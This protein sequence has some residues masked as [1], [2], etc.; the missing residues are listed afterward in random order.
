MLDNNNGLWKFRARTNRSLPVN[1]PKSFDP[2]LSKNGVVRPIESKTK[3]AQALGLIDR[4]VREKAASPT[5]A[6]AGGS[7][8]PSA[9]GSSAPLAGDSNDAGGDAATRRAQ[10][11]LRPSTF[12]GPGR[13]GD[14][15]W[16]VK[17]ALRP[18]RAAFGKRELWVFNDNEEHRLTDKVGGGN[19]AIRPYNAFGKY[20]AEPLAA[21]VTTGCDGKGYPQLTEHVKSIIDNDFQRIEQLVS[22]GAYSTVTFSSD[23]SGGLGCKIFAATLGDDVKKYI[24]KRLR[25]LCSIPYCMPSDDGDGDP[26]AA[27]SI[28]ELRHM[29]VEAGLSHAG[30]SPHALLLRSGDPYVE[31]TT[32]RARAPPCVRLHAL[33]ARD[34]AHVQKW[35][36]AI[37][38]RA[39]YHLS[40]HTSA[41]HRERG[42]ALSCMNAEC[43]LGPDG[44]SVPSCR[45]DHADS[46]S[47]CAIVRRVWRM[48]LAHAD[49]LEK[50][51]LRARAQMAL[52]TSRRK[53]KPT[54]QLQLIDLAKAD[55]RSVINLMTHPQWSRVGRQFETQF[56]QSV[57]GLQLASP[58]F[59]IADPDGSVSFPVVLRIPLQLAPGSANVSID[60]LL[61]RLAVI[62]CASGPSTL[63]DE[64][65]GVQWEV[66]HGA[67]FTR[68]FAEIRVQHFS[69]YAVVALAADSVAPALLPCLTTFISAAQ[70]ASTLVVAVDTLRAFYLARRQGMHEQ[71]PLPPL[72]PPA[73]ASNPSS[74]YELLIF[75]CSPRAGPLPA[76]SQEALI[77]QNEC[78]LQGRAH[79]HTENGLLGGTIATLQTLV[80]R[81][82]PRRFHFIG[83]GN[84][85]VGTSRLMGFTSPGSDELHVATPGNLV[86]IF[87]AHKPHLVLLNAC[88]T[89]ST[90][91]RQLHEHG[92]DVVICWRTKV[93]DEAACVFAKTFHRLCAEGWSERA[94]FDSAAHAVT[95]VTRRGTRNSDAMTLQVQK[96]EL[97]DPSVPPDDGLGYTPLPIHAGIPIMIC[98]E[99]H[100][101]PRPPPS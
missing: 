72:P 23:G 35:Q 36:W 71:P 5:V 4:A 63:F 101:L 84:I 69:L 98:A 22:R 25:A 7:S 33:R 44:T 86:G 73:V 34:A 1:V 3:L 88:S 97:R 46:S 59:S 45:A 83:H 82:R 16:E 92:I 52:E 64:A 39:A 100:L 70:H 30:A 38:Q 42:A 66:A 6:S 62:R 54:T 75:A 2:T 21:G 41:E 79:L 80:L 31:I 28:S 77:V 14:F 15:T 65:R 26:L 37:E 99:G 8:A 18:P 76:A 40:A 78:G 12:Q 53:G 19:A 67:G 56:Q 90:F 93:F 29:I 57:Q 91:G 68:E 96:F 43:R 51:E 94:A 60:R 47:P 81:D 49:C 10:I 20:A 50:P 27:M 87:Q 89:E 9:G 48:S 11:T 61:D 32:D 58:L 95:L 24:E 55:Q 85:L 74:P 17:E 13:V